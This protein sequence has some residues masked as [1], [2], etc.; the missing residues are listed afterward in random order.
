MTQPIHTNPSAL[1]ATKIDG[2]LRLAVAPPDEAL[3]GRFFAACTQND[4]AGPITPAQRRWVVANLEANPSWQAYWKELETAYGHPV[5]WPS[6]DFTLNGI[7]HATDAQAVRQP[8]RLVPLHTRMARLAMVASFLIL[9]VYGGLWGLGQSM[10]PATYPLASIDAFDDVDAPQTR[11]SEA[12]AAPF[13]LGLDALRAAHENTLGLFP[14]YAPETVEQGIAHLQEAYSQAPDAFHRAETAFFLAKAHLM[15]ADPFGA[16]RWLTLSLDQ[17][18]A[19][20]RAE[21]QALLQRLS[22]AME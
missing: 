11:G 22:T 7:G 20:Y 4:L 14:H 5:Q 15:K 18:V 2:L 10:I 16:H 8:A 1:D 6:A 17:N 3:L 19:D 12:E 21:S 13:T 9:A